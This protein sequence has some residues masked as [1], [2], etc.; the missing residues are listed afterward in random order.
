MV[1][2]A[3]WATLRRQW[4][5]HLTA[6]E[7]LT[8]ERAGG[9]P[10]HN[11]YVDQDHAVR[12]LTLAAFLL[13]TT[14]A[15]AGSDDALPQAAVAAPDSLFARTDSAFLP[16]RTEADWPEEFAAA[17][18]IRRDAGGHIITVEEEP[19]SES[20]DWSL[21]YRH[22]FDTAGRTLRF[23]SVGRY[24]GA[25]P[26]VTEARFVQDVASSGAGPR[27]TRTL[28]DSTGADVDPRECGHA[29]EF[30]D[31]VPLPNL[32]ALIEAK[33]VPRGP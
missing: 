8:H 13:L 12:T 11:F 24:F 28:R 18:T 23:E 10:S 25:C 20:G 33:R 30:F 15:C 3:G 21:V 2:R 1:L 7:E 16:I 29:Y 22:T 9:Q 31:G 4:L 32:V 17:I 14:L 19:R 6:L 5:W 27:V 26:G